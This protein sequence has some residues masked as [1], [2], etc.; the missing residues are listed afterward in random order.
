MAFLEAELSTISGKLGAFTTVWFAKTVPSFK[1]ALDLIHATATTGLSSIVG[2]PGLGSLLGAGDGR[3]AEEVCLAEVGCER[4]F[5]PV[6]RS[7]SVCGGD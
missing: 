6:K 2:D 7:F 3:T 4:C 5:W 1:S